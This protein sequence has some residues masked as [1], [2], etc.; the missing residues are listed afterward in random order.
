MEQASWPCCERRHQRYNR[1]GWISKR[2]GMDSKNKNKNNKENRTKQDSC[3]S[4]SATRQ[5]RRKR[6][7]TRREQASENEEENEQ[8]SRDPILRRDHTEEKNPEK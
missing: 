8:L 5:K 4:I 7:R 2:D 1:E 3:K 6:T